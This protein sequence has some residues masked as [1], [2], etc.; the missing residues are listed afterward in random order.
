MKSIKKIL[1]LFLTIL[2][3][4]SAITPVM[5][6]GDITVVI[7]G[8]QIAFDVPP[9]IINDRTMVPLRAIFEALGA[10]VDWDN[11]TQTVSSTKDNTTI[12]L[13]IN[14]ATMYVNGTVVTLDSPAC[15][16]NGRTLVPVRAISEAFGTKVDWIGNENI[17]SIITKEI[18]IEKITFN[19]TN[20]TVAVGES[21]ELSVSIYP[22]NAANKILN[23]RSSNTAIVTVD[24]GII[25]GITSGTATII[26]ESND[27]VSAECEITVPAV[28]TNVNV[29]PILYTGNGDKVISN[30]NIPA[31]AYYAELTHDGR[32]NFISKL[33]YGEESYEHFNLSNEIGKCHL[34]VALYDEG[35]VGVDNGMLEVKADGNWTIEFKP[36]SGTTTTNIHGS[37]QIVT[38]IF[39]AKQ[40]K[41]VFNLTHDGKR[42]FIVK[43][44]KYNGTESYDYKSL[45][46]EIGAYSG[47]TMKM[48]EVGQKYF[49]YIIADGNWTID[50]ALGDSVTTYSSLTVPNTNY[51]DTNNDNNYNN[52]NDEIQSD[53]NKNNNVKNDKSDEEI[54]TKDNTKDIIKALTNALKFIKISDD[55]TIAIPPNTDEGNKSYNDVMI[56]GAEYALPYIEKAKKLSEDNANISSANRSLIKMAYEDCN[57]VMQTDSETDYL[58]TKGYIISI[59]T[60]LQ[61][62]IK[63]MNND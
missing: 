56:K 55:N 14:N 28:E 32:R 40:A 45:C 3:L 22:Q 48:L 50:M 62:V 13:T 57:T 54:T 52:N 60:S 7:D 11:D 34:Q 30:V 46:N 20:D 16:I 47:T 4:V 26:C 38:G 37:G 6:N 33:H 5:A 39:T 53:K 61:G 31:G 43:V 51:D 41:N 9:Q 44:I 8:K 25:N 21:K 1:S 42:N 27:G 19:G 36:I 49:F 15:L 63:D 59:R 2:L 18:P 29:K 17:V 12:S 23:W 10:T 24:N 58:I 35:N